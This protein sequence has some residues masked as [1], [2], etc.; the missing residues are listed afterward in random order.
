MALVAGNHFGAPHNQLVLTHGAE[1]ARVRLGH[2][3]YQVEQFFSRA[4][5][6]QQAVSRGAATKI[7]GFGF[8]LRGFGELAL[9]QQWQGFG[10]QL[11]GGFAK[12]GVQGQGRVRT[13]DADTM[14]G[15][16][17]AC[18]GA[19]DH[20]VQGYAGFGFAV[21]QYPVGR[22]ASTVA[23]QQGTMQVEGA[24]ADACQQLFAQQVAIIE[25][26]DV[27][28]VQFANALD[29]QWVV[30]VFRSVNRNA[31]ACTQLGNRTVEVVFFGVVSM[32]EYSSNFVAC[33]EQGFDACAAN[34]VIGENNG[35]QTH[36]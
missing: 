7:S 6:L 8:V 31:F 28:G 30:G 23:W 3:T 9:W 2:G 36:D 22:C 12:L 19:F 10:Q 11:G 35:F 20:A 33:I 24:L 21:Y 5:P 29:P 4:V 18:V 34:I 26:E 16:D 14:L 25:R 32:G 17:I 1:G 13:L 27:V 15:Q